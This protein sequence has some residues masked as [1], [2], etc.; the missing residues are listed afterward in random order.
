M[1]VPTPEENPQPSQTKKKKNKKK[2][3]TMALIRVSFSDGVED[4]RS[5]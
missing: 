5:C 4:L 3:P 2:E 1:L